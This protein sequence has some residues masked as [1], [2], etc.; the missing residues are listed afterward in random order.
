[1]PERADLR[2]PLL[3]LMGMVG[4]LR[5][6][7]RGQRGLHCCYYAPPDAWREISMRYAL[8]RGARDENHRRSC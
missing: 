6:D 1:L 3:V 8:G 2:T 5:R 7:V 4:V